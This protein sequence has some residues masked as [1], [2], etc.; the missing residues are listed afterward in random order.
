LGHSNRKRENALQLR[1][2]L[3]DLRAIA[4]AQAASVTTRVLDQEAKR[5]RAVIEEIEEIKKL[6]SETPTALVAQIDVIAKK[7]E[8]TKKKDDAAADLAMRQSMAKWIRHEEKIQATQRQD[9][10]DQLHK[11]LEQICEKEEITIDTWLR[12]HHI[13]HSQYYLSKQAGAKPVKGKVSVKLA[14]NIKTAI[15]HDAV[16][17]GLI[18]NTVHDNVHNV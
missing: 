13:G 11:L 7:L 15:L 4:V 6:K 8:A 10:A 1:R 9:D 18:D 2:R 17:L 3:N 14:D 12:D 16:A 5:R